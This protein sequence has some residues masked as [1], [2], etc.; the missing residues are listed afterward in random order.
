[1]AKKE[2]MKNSLSPNL[3]YRFATLREESTGRKHVK[4]F[5]NVNSI[6]RM[7]HLQKLALWASGE[8]SIPP[9][10][11][12]FGHNLATSAK[13]MGIPLDSSLFP[14]QRC[15]T[16]LLPGVNCTVRIEKNTAKVHGRRKKSRMP[17]QN[18]VVYTCHFCS[19]RNLKK[20]TP[21]GHMKE[22]FATRSEPISGSKPDSSKRRKPPVSQKNIETRDSIS[23]TNFSRHKEDLTTKEI[24]FES[25]PVTPVDRTGLL[26]KE[27]RKMNGFSSNKTVGTDKSSAT[28]EMGKSSG[29]SS[30]RRRKAWCSLK[31]IAKSGEHGNTQGISNL[32][33]PFLI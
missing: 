29:R 12:L 7:Q 16:A 15:E 28:S 18:N 30:K 4:G 13:A 3:G 20:G 31:E 9:L 26:A 27:K 6:L 24:P 10:A 23:E 32:A 1:M 8:A 11:A 19:N 33:I 14:C 17:T 2:K 5:K 21:K 25:S 22:I